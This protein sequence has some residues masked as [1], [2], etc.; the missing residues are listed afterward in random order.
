[1]GLGHE[2]GSL[3]PGSVADL[4]IWSPAEGSV[5]QHR[6]ALAR[7]LHERVFAWVTLGDERNLIE[8]WVAGRRLFSK[9]TT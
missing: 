3:A 9:P 7:D 5:A 2:I 1:L 8:T 4:C 6:D